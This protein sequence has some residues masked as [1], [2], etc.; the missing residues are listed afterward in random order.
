LIELLGIVI[1]V[2]CFAAAF[3]LIYLFERV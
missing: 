2:A 1:A 3:A